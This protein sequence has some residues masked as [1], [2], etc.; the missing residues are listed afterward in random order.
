MFVRVVALAAIWLLSFGRAQAALVLSEQ[1]GVTYETPTLSGFGTDGDDM[2]GLSV[3]V[4][5]ADASTETAI[6][7]A[8]ATVGYGEA[9]G[10]G[11]TINQGPGSTWSNPF[12]F[13]NNSGQAVSRITLHGAGANT[14]FDRSFGGAAGTTSSANGRDVQETTSISVTQDVFATYFDRVQLAGGTPVGDL[15]GG[16]RLEFS[17]GLADGASFS[18]ITDTDTGSSSLIPTPEPSAGLLVTCFVS[19]ISWRRRQVGRN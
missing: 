13:A 7:Q 19:L 18:F 6:W 12:S 17:A 16:L 4:V 8:G 10:T 2:L 5:F 9:V 11:W 3:S 14:V 15:F 1:D